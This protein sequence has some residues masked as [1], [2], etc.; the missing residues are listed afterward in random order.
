MAEGKQFARPKELGSTINVS[1]FGAVHGSIP[2]EQYERIIARKPELK[3]L[4]EV[5]TE[6]PV[7]ASSVEERED[8]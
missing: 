7:P 8:N 6:V 4:F 5:Y 3:D 1:G 2:V